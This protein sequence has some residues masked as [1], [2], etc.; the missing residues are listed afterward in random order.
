M[1]LFC[2]KSVAHDGDGVTLEVLEYIKN[3]EA[4]EFD[5]FDCTVLVKDGSVVESSRVKKYGLYF[6][7]EDTPDIIITQMKEGT[8][9]MNTGDITED[10][11]GI[12]L[13]ALM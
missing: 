2:V 9:F 7:D 5:R 3:M 12:E 4:L 10:V 8:A 1:Q 6:G 11:P 13:A